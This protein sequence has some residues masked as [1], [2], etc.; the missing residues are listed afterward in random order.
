MLL[1]MVCCTYF[2]AIWYSYKKLSYRDSWEGL[3]GTLF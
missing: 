1:L 2:F 3:R